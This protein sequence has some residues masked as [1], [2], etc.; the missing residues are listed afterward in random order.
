MKGFVIAVVLL[1][2]SFFN[3]VVERING[4]GVPAH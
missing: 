3:I 1:Q 2:R 4:V